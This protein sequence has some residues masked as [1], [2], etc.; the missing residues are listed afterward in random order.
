MCPKLRKYER[1]SMETMR[2]VVEKM[3]GVDGAVARIEEEGKCS[4]IKSVAPVE[5]G[6]L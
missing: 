2:Q 3:D 6:Y 4:L 5:I 1:G